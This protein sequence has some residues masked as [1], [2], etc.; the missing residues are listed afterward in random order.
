[1]P[2]WTT[3]Y[4]SLS[5]D[6]FLGFGMVFRI[7]TH[8]QSKKP[9]SHSGTLDMDQ[10]DDEGCEGAKC[11]MEAV[12]KVHIIVRQKEEIAQETTSSQ[13]AG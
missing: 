9:A 8:E 6:L 5:V 12:R 4:H 13:S 11:H 3:T 7:N 10:A 2:Q 1:M